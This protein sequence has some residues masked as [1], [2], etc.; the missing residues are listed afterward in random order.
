MSLFEDRDSLF[1]V[2]Y[3]DIYDAYLKIVDQ[4][5]SFTE[6]SM[7]ADI[8]QWKDQL[9]EGDRRVCK[10]VF[11]G[12]TEA[13]GSVGC[14]WSNV[15]AKRFQCPEVEALAKA[16]SYQETVHKFGYG[17][18]IS[19]LN[20]DIAPLLA[21]NPVAKD[22]LD[23]IE[24]QISED[25]K[26]LAKSLAIFSGAIEGVSLFSSFVILLSFSRDSLLPGMRQILSWSVIDE[27]NHSKMGIFLYGKLIEEDPSLK[28]NEEEVYQ[29]FREVVDKE[30]A[31]VELA[32][33]NYYSPRI[34][35]TQVI[36]FIKYRANNRLMALGFK[37]LY[38]LDMKKVQEV[39]YW[40]NQCVS[41]IADNDFF[42][43]SKNG[44]AYQAIVSQDFDSV[45]ITDFKAPEWL[46]LNA[47]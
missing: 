44:Q 21:E 15:V 4:P 13:E 2:Q 38:Q 12:F 5:W 33:Q 10:L 17:H 30:L 37:P 36:E 27:D 9:T 43:S 16:C 46:N 19:T 32:F 14:Y 26:D 23:H 41:G 35:K 7:E 20:L 47:A 24:N 39:T 22:K 8:K 25:K 40:F 34:N 18:V 6:V 11:A 28:P 31:F 45:D 3:P 42:F 29:G 1:P